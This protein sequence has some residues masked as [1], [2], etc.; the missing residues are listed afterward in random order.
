MMTNDPKPKKPRTISPHLLQRSFGSFGA[1]LIVSHLEARPPDFKPFG[2]GT[3]SGL[4]FAFGFTEDLAPIVIITTKQGHNV[5]RVDP[6]S[7]VDA[8]AAYLTKGLPPKGL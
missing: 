2:D 7:I 4:P 1:T 8:C 6:S 3:V 5:F